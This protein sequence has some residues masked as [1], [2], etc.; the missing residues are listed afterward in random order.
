MKTTPLRWDDGET[1]DVYLSHA[2]VM[3]LLEHGE[4]IKQHGIMSDS[5]NYT[6]LITLQHEEATLPAIY[7]PRRGERPLW[8]FP[9]GTLCLRE[10]AAFLT[11]QVSGW[12]VVPPTV[13]RE[14]FLGMGSMQFYVDHDPELHYFRLDDRFLPQLMRLCLFDVLVNNADRKGGHCIVDAGGHLWGIDHG[15]TFN[16]EPKLRTVIWDFTGQPIPTEL[17]D[18]VRQLCAL[19]EQPSDYQTALEALLDKRERHAFRQRIHQVLQE[20]LFPL[21]SDRQNY[22]WPPI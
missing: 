5:S 9:D 22:P 7:K 15:I 12:D 2:E 18:D 17:L 6:F 19:L 8:D 16:E 11:S 20:G 4:I 21:P 10:R 13:L 14:G 1:P 3:N